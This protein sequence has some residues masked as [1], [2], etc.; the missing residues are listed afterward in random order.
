MTFTVIDAGLHTLIQ[1]LGRP[2]LSSMGVSRSGAFDRR[3]LQQG[4]ALV[5]NTA[6]AAGLEILGGRIDLRADA[7]HVIALTGATGGATIDGDPV[8]HGRAMAIHAG[9]RLLSAAPV[10]GIRTYLAVAGG[11]SVAPILGSCSTDTLSDLGPAP[12]HSG[13]VLDVCTTRGHGADDEIPALLPYG[14]LTLRVSLGPRD[15]WFTPETVRQFLNATW[16]V[17]AA[18]SRVGIRLDGPVITRLSGE[19]LPSEPC[20]RGS[21]QI[22]SEGQPIVFGPDHPVTGGYPVIAVIHDADTDLL[23]QARPG[24]PIR[25]FLRLR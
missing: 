1:D 8:A 6:G 19:E 5:G 16:I 4:N 12:V 20:V 10:T 14:E 7:D 13:D 9:Q 15:D 18:A 25:F 21:I 11:I 24:Q 2:G 23:G 22:T 17:D 3:S